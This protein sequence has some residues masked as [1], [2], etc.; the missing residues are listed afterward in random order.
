MSGADGPFLTIIGVTA[1][2]VTSGLLNEA[3][4]A[5]HVAQRQ[6]KGVMS[7]TLIVRA[8]SDA[9]SLG[10]PVQRAVHTLDPDIPVHR[11]RTLDRVRDD[12]LAEQRKGPA[13]I[14]IVGVLALGLATICLYAVIVFGVRQRTR[15]IGVRMGVW[16][17]AE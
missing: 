14:G 12:A 3:P 13:V 7:L 1:N 15:E 9:A 2:A 6:H 16:C 11:V 4:D 10:A 17:A 8:R 5:A